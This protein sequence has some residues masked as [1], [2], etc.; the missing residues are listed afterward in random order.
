M[1]KAKISLTFMYSLLSPF[2]LFMIKQGKVL[3]EPPT[4]KS[5]WGSIHFRLRTYLT[6]TAE[7]RANH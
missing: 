2:T 6:T 1:L 3:T 7:Q 4:L 5:A